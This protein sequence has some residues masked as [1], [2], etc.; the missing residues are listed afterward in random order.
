MLITRVQIFIW[1]Y[2]LLSLSEQCCYRLA[3]MALYG[4]YSN[5]QSALG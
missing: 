3:L 5:L 1:P 4:C 2:H